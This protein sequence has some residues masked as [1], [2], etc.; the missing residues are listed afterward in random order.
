MRRRRVQRTSGLRFP[1]SPPRRRGRADLQVGIQNDER[2]RRRPNDGFGLFARVRSGLFRTFERVDIDED[3]HRAV[4]FFIEGQIAT[5]QPDH[6]PLQRPGRKNFGAGSRFLFARRDCGVIVGLRAANSTCRLFSIIKQNQK[7]ALSQIIQRN[8]FH[9]HSPR[10]AVQLNRHVLGAYGLIFLF[11][12]LMP[13]RSGSIK[14][15]RAIFS[16]SKLALP[17][18]G[19]R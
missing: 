11:A 2:I 10:R 7:A 18:G 4:H 12:L 14:P 9:I 13:V 5:A 6:W 17:V 15:S 16:M 1:P 8:D 3:H 19:S